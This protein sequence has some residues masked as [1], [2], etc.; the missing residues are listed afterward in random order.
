[1]FSML[2]AQ[3][4]TAYNGDQLPNHSSHAV[5][6][7]APSNVRADVL[8]STSL[9][10]SW[11]EIPPTSRNGIIITYEAV[12]EPL[13]TFEGRLTPVLLNTSDLYAAL[14]ELEEFVR[15][16]VSV[17]AYTSVGPGPYSNEVFAMTQEDRKWSSYI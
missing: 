1:M 4:G 5:P 7:V 12:F 3:I 15:Y 6:D 16:N 11:E 10:I 2:L 14:N 9:N 13:D 17:R 8:G